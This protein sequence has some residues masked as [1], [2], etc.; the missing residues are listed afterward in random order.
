MAT[1]NKCNAQVDDGV[2]VCPICGE[3]MSA[4]QQQQ[5]D[6]SAKLNSLN[7]TADTTAQFDGADIE[8]NKIMALLSYIG[9]LFL[10]PILAAP[11]SKFARFHANQGIVL[12]ILE[13]AYGIATGI[14]LAI[15][16]FISGFLTMILSIVLGLVS[17]VF[18]VFAILGIMNAFNGKAKELPFIGKFKILK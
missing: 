13:A 10:V 18:F 6:F 8:Q 9:F 3:E 4:P 17:I 1:C 7:N 2:K 12:F 14:I 5:A 11:T 15:L 16:G